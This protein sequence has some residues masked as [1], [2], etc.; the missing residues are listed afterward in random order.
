MLLATEST[1]AG[2]SNGSAK[3]TCAFSSFVESPDRSPF[4]GI[5]NPRGQR[6]TL[7]LHPWRSRMSDQ[8]SIPIPQSPEQRLTRVATILTRGFMRVGH[9]AEN[10]PPRNLGD[11]RLH[12]L[13]VVSE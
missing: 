4:H 5:H 3:A 7:P 8:P 2:E 11:F 12:D 9:V 13:D 6:R 1:L 10:H